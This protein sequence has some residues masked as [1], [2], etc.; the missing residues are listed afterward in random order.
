[1]NQLWF[2]HYFDLAQTKVPCD[3]P[4]NRFQEFLMSDVLTVLRN[5]PVQPRVQCSLSVGRLTFWR[6]CSIVLR[7]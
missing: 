2:W 7:L 3:I 6:L 1:M 4:V 5:L